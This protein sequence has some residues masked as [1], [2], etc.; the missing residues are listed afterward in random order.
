MTSDSGCFIAL[1]LSRVMCTRLHASATAISPES[2]LVTPH[3]H[4]TVA[5][6]GAQTVARLSN[7]VLDFLADFRG[8]PGL[9][10]KT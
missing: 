5:A 1:I 4:R 7:I 2:A 8:G 6:N 9:G 10:M 3:Q